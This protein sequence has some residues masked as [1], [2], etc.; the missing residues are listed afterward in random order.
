[1]PGVAQ[2]KYQPWCQ[3]E[4]HYVNERYP[5]VIK[6]ETMKQLTEL[7]KLDITLYH[8]IR[9]CL[10]DI[11]DDDDDDDIYDNFPAWDTTRFERNET[12]QKNYTD[13]KFPVP[14]LPQ[15]WLRRF[16]RIDEAAAN[17]TDVLSDGEV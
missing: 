17:N 7:N 12:I 4:S 13:Y 5:L 9:D 16:E 6:N 1:M 10:D 3:A 2:T 8:E 14:K 11:D 15:Q